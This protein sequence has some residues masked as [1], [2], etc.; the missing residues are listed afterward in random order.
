MSICLQG[1]IQ[2]FIDALDRAVK[3]NTSGLVETETIINRF[4]IDLELK[5]GASFTERATYT[6]IYNISGLGF[7]M[8]FRV[9]CSDNY[10]GPKCSSFCV[11]LEGVYTC[12]SEGRPICI[13]INRDPVTDCTT[14]LS[15]YDPE[16]NCTQCLMGRTLSSNCSTC[17]PG[18]DPSTNCDSCLPGYENIPGGTPCS[19]AVHTATIYYDR[20]KP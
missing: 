17:P 15:G 14:C 16:Q 8:S 7:D 2:F 19:E 12:N 18:Y 9:Q 13:E 20:T 6:G 3:R 1:R 11:P 10:H 4:P 5:L